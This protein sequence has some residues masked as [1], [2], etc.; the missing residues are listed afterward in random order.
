MR[1]SQAAS[2]QAPQPSR[3]SVLGMFAGAAAASGFSPLAAQTFERP[4]VIEMFTSQGCSS[5]PPADKLLMGVARRPN[6]IALSLPVDYWDY[7]GWKDTFGKPEHTL[8]QKGYAK[9]RGDGQVYTPQAVVDGMKH[10]VGSDMKAIEA[11]ASGAFGKA[12]AMSAP[13]KTRE[14]GGNLIVEIGA[15]QDGAPRVASLMIFRVSS[16]REVQIGRGENS[17]RRLHYVNVVRSFETAGEWNGKPARFEISRDRLLGP[18]NDGWVL[19]LQA[20]SA[21]RPGAILAAA[22]SAGI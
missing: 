11:A 6:V 8:R 15:S 12:G 9:M 18:E 16:S 3:R 20:G 10:V 14:S 19:L 2:L 13:M 21:K 17:G 22:K 5:C 1:S 4:V 7:I